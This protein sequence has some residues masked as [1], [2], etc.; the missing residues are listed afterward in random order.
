MS[1]D[2]NFKN[3]LLLAGGLNPIVT[4]NPTQY[5]DRHRQYFDPET[6]RFTAMK[7]KY[8][9]DFMDAQVQGLFDNDPLAWETYR[10][11]MAN[12]VRPSAAIQRHFDD[13]KI[14]LFESPKIE[15]IRPGTKI[16]SMGS[17]WLALNPDNVS[18]ASG[19]GLVRR[20]NAVWNYYDENGNLCSEPIIAE[21]ER[22]NANDSDA[23]NSQ[24]ISK[25]YFNIICQYNDATRQIDTNTRMILGTGAYRVTGFSDFEQEF[26]G[27]YASVRLLYFSV[28]YEE[29]NEDIDDMENHVAGGKAFLAKL[30]SKETPPETQNGVGFTGTVPKTMTAGDT[31]V[32]TAAYFTDGTAGAEAITWTYGGAVDGSYTATVSGNSL[33]VSAYQWSE[34]PLVVTASYGNES[35]SVTIAI[36][37][38]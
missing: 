23:Q 11:R 32:L 8:S 16:V 4:N 6:R 7:A 37:G 20:C 10:L 17:T 31:T 21:N 19:S 33:T 35:A 26:T 1:A 15:Y 14:V 27:D 36:E 9:S 28:R 30:N 12:V 22:A 38:M 24:L 3:A 25:G 13:Y 2:V 5:A 18:G 29:P 34:T